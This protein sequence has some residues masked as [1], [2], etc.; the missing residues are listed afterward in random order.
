MSSLCIYKSRKM[1][2]FHDVANI[3]V[4]QIDL[5]NV[6]L[7]SSYSYQT[8]LNRQKYKADLVCN[9]TCMTRIR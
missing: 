7:I 8:K 5:V 4:I 2:I 9:V 6:K 3:F 1:T